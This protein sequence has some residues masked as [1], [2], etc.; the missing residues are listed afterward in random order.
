ML[1]KTHSISD[2]K[3]QLKAYDFYKYDTST[4]FITAIQMALESAQYNELIPV[5]GWG[6]Y[7]TIRDLDRTLFDDAT[8]DTTISDKTV[9]M[10]STSNLVADMYVYGVGVPSGSQVDSITDSTD[11]ELNNNATLTGTNVT[12]SFNRLNED[13]YSVYRSEVNYACA[14]FMEFHA[15]QAL[16]NRTGTSMSRSQGG[17]NISSSG[18]IGEKQAANE[19]RNRGNIMLSAAGYSIV[20][21]IKR[22]DSIHYAR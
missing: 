22:G 13:Q 19:F 17:V 7:G 3:K 4:K 21:S 1:S 10:D 11:F 6:T 14:E 5:I 20:S 18:Q 15:R 12:L 2:V 9:T 16:Y 8:C